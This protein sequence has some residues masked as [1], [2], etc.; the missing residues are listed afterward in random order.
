VG[1]GCLRA[2]YP[3]VVFR[4]LDSVSREVKDCVER[5]D[6]GNDDECEGNGWIEGVLV[7]Q[8]VHH[9]DRQCGE[10]IDRMLQSAMRRE[11][12]GEINDVEANACHQAADNWVRNE[13]RESQQA[14]GSGDVF[15]NANIEYRKN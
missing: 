8:D 5:S 15:E 10:V 11:L 12:N 13:I 3:D 2:E 4:L 9:S 14:K 6:A 7:R 1:D